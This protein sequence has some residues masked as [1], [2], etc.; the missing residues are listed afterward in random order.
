MKLAIY[1]KGKR[2]DLFDDETIQ[3]T[4]KLTDIEKLSN[5]FTDFS[6]TFTIPATPNNNEIF[7]HY[8]DMD[9]DNTFNANIRVETYLELNTLPFKL[10]TIQLESV[11]VKNGRPDNYKITFYGGLRQLTDLFGDDLI[12]RLDYQKDIITGIET[13]E[14]ESLSQFDYEY[15]G[16]N[17]LQSITSPIKNGNVLTPLIISANRDIG[18]LT[19]NPINDITLEAGAIKSD[20]LKSSLRIYNIIKAIEVK[21]GITFS[22]DFLHRSQ[23]QN[24]FMWLNGADES[25]V[26]TK[27]VEIENIDF[28]APVFDI[29]NNTINLEPNVLFPFGYKINIRTSSNATKPYKINVYKNGFKVS[30]IEVT[31]FTSQVYGGCKV[32]ANETAQVYFEIEASEPI[33]YNINL[34]VLKLNNLGIP[35]L[36][37][38]TIAKTTDTGIL[39]QPSVRMEINLPE[40]KVIDFLSG[41][42]KMFKL[43]ILPTSV[44]TFYLD[45]L[46]SFYNKGN[47]LDITDY[48]D[49]EDITYS[50]PLVYKEIDFKF[51]E[52]E[53]ILGKKF[54]D[55]NNNIGYGDL[56]S[57][58]PQIQGDTLEIKLPFENMLF[59]NLPY[60]QGDESNNVSNIVIG[61]NS[62]LNDDNTISINK[63]KPILFYYVGTIECEIDIKGQFPNSP[64]S[65]IAYY[66]ICLNIDDL[67]LNQ[68]TQTLN[69]GAENDPFLLTRIDNSLYFNYWSNWINTIYDLKQRKIVVNSFL[70]DRFIEELSL[71]DRLIIGSNRFK[72]QEYNI[73]L[74]TGE[75]KLT[76]FKDIYEFSPPQPK[77]NISPIIMN[78]GAKYFTFPINGVQNEWLANIIYLGD[79]DDWIEF[80]TNNQGEGN[81]FVT[82]KILEKSTQTPP[83]VFESRQATLTIEVDG[84]DFEIEITQLGLEE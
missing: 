76:L 9:V 48:V 78:A 17:W 22:R 56:K 26:D 27:R 55:T 7:N 42:M 69:W 51:E 79:E 50:R 35:Q 24:I 12:S 67:L 59:E 62:S 15:T 6:Q 73:N 21:Y 65:N 49:I 83:L 11:T 77:V 41:I 44:N 1:I 30:V 38:A 29:V 31:E 23:F 68:V 71:N 60:E 13:K 28:G 82:I 40:L 16:A 53:N 80:L 43:I 20:E 33:T 34:Y 32:F 25:M 39:F 19:P 2:L 45:T 46:D 3:I 84:E 63:S 72:I 58:Y 10:G 64:L 18:I 5:I 14:W 74:T 57:I 75:T 81:G 4:S 8:Y 66:N 52:T 36:P 47:L 61:Q 70:P 54:R 37:N